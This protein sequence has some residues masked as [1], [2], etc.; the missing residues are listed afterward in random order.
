MRNYEF[1]NLTPSII[2]YSARILELRKVGHN[3]T[4]VKISKGV[5]K[6]VLNEVKEVPVSDRAAQLAWCL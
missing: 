1:A 2:R 6:Y 4:T 5:T 3:I